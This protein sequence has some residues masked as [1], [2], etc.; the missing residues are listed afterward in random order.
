MLDKDIISTSVS[1]AV[2]K[3]PT[4]EKD[5]RMFYFAQLPHTKIRPTYN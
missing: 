1:E 4:G 3:I 5:D 2:E